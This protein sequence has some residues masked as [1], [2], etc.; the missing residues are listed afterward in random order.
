MNNV[1]K[2]F[3]EISNIPRQSGKEE[4]ISRYVVDFAIKRNLKYIHDKYNNVIIFKEA[5]T[6]YENNPSIILQSHMDMI[7]TK[8]K[9]STHNFDT[10]S[11]ELIEYN[12]YIKANNTTLGADNGIGMAI[13]LS[14]LDDDNLKHPK[15]EVI[16]TTEE[17]TTMN[18][19]KYIDLSMLTSQKMI[20]LDNMYEDELWIGCASCH[21]WSCSLVPTYEPLNEKGYSLYTIDFYGFTGGHSGLDIGKK[22]GNPILL[23]SNL[24]HDLSKQTKI[25]IN[26]IDGG[27][28]LNVIPV[29]CRCNLFINEKDIDIIN[30]IIIK[31]KIEIL[32]ELDTNNKI[33]IDFYKNNDIKDNNALSQ[34]CMDN[35]LDFLTNFKNGVQKYDKDTNIILSSNFGVISSNKQI[36]NIDFSMRCNQEIYASSFIN[37]TEENLNKYNIKINNYLEL[38]GYEHKKQSDFLNKCESE[39]VKYFNKKPKLIKMHV[40]LEAG[41]F[42]SK[43]SNLDFV[44]ISPNIYDA[45][46]PSERVSISSTNRIYEYITILLENL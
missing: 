26:S 17:E 8:T 6:G 22:R 15:L 38:P 18:G 3:K 10:D 21:E 35:I 45:H 2:F 14:I 33:K 39:Y 44:A 16:F 27:T 25:Y 42:N 1:F 36:I 34:K 13:A 40:G 32:H 20:S 31:N 11:L 9:E 43:I 30:K 29:N 41:F 19:A 7:C 12:D 37:Y 23:M 46:S 4:K 28:R 24:L 5:S